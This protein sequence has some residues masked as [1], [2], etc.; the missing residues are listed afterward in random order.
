MRDLGHTVIERDP[1]LPRS[2]SLAI[3]AR[4]FHGIAEDVECMAHPERL[5]RRTRSVARLGRL[6]TPA[7]RRS[8]AI[9]RAAAAAL[10][11]GH[12]EAAVLLF[13]GSV[14]GPWPV[15][16]FHER[17]A[18]V[19]GYK[20]TARVAFQPLWNLVDRPAAMLPWGLD[21]N[22]LPTAGQ[23]AGRPAAGPPG[24]PPGGEARLLAVAA[25]AEAARG[26]PERRP[27]VDPLPEE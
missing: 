2:T 24:P 13:P 22:G 27:P 15:G 3:D 7:L 5:E 4:Y 23:I 18:L 11:E 20:D 16:H 6:L 12:R 19:T 10:D 17:G 21:R 9:A 1:E 8:G 25:Q 26:W 14:Q